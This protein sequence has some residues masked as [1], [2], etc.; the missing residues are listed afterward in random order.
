MSVLNDARYHFGLEFLRIMAANPDLTPPSPSRIVGGIGPFDFSGAADPAAVDLFIKIDGALDSV[1]AIDFVTPPVAAIGA[2]TVDE[3]FAAITA[4]SYTNITAS[5]ES[6]TNRILIVAG[7][8]AYL[9]VYGEAAETSLI[10]Q[11][12]GVKFLK[13]DTMETSAETITNKDEEQITQ[14]DAKGRD[15]EILTDG[16]RKGL[17]QVWTDTAGDY[18]IR[19]LV[20]GGVID[21][22]TGEY[23]VPDSSSTKKY[24]YAELFW[25]RYAEGSNLERNRVGYVQQ[26]IFVAKATFGDRSAGRD[27]IK[28]IYNVTAPSYKDASGV[29]Q[30]DSKELPLTVEE[31]EALDVENV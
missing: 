16:Y 25:A 11:G 30:P 29:V 28:W 8:G 23:T 5:K 31:Y 22:S 26:K 9:Q 21:S 15:T 10:G 24:F 7:S 2:V 3:L 18:L 12:L 1:V 14:T 17:T 27:W 6:V 20:E 4:A 19:Q 13:S